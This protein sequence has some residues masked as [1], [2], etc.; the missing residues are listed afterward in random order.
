MYLGCF[1]GRVQRFTVVDKSD[2]SSSRLTAPFNF[3]YYQ[4]AHHIFYFKRRGSLW[5]SYFCSWPCFSPFSCCLVAFLGLICSV[6]MHQQGADARLSTVC[7]SLALQMTA[8]LVVWPPRARRVESLC[9]RKSRPWR[10][11]K[12]RR[13]APKRIDTAGFACPNQQCRYFGNID[14][15]VHALVGD[16]KHGQVER[17]QTFRCQACGTTFT[18][19][20]HTPLYR[21]KTPS[22]Q[23]AMVLSALAEGLD[24]SAAERVFGYRQG[25]IITWLSRAGQRSQSLH[26]RFFR[27]LHLTHLQLDEIRTRL[28]RSTQV[29]WLWLAID[30]RTKLLPVLHQGPRTQ[31]AAHLLI[32]SLRLPARAPGPRLPPTLY[33]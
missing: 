21:L 13:G 4:E 26:E 15:R 18:A 16:G 23:I 1:H 19:R 12:S 25:T 6:P 22:H 10:E 27:H 33:V 30:P 31:Q 7:S 8:L 17:I 2:F 5:F 14:A 20:R 28:R 11:V 9:L 29:L 3:T 24:P 32:H